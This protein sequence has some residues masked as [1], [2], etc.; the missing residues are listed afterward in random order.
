MTY[1]RLQAGFLSLGAVMDWC[2]RYGL[3]WAVSITMEV[4]LCREALDQALEGA[5]PAIFNS[6]QG[7]QCTSNDFTG[8]LAAAGVLISMDGRGRALDNVFIERLW[9]TVKY[10]EV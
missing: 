6:D 10:E 1:I 2:S 3:S 7:A 5:R 8:R 9:R 4:G